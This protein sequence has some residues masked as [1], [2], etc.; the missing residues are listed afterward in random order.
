VSEEAVPPWR[1]YLEAAGL[2]GLATAVCFVFR[3][4][5]QATD[6]AMLYLLVVV[7]VASRRRLGAAVL[8]SVLGI[9]AFD[10]VFVPP[11]YTFAVHNAAYVLTFGVMLAVALV[12][13][14]L[15]ARIRTQAEDAREREERTVALY[16]LSREL[17]DTEGRGNQIALI[18]RHLARAAQRARIPYTAGAVSGIT[19]EEAAKLAPDVIWFQ[20]YRL[21]RDDHRAGFDLLRRAQDA[22]VHVLVMTVDTPGRA[23]RPGELRNGLTL[24]FRPTLRTI[25]QAAVSPG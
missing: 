6:V 24:P 23:K 25:M 7:A 2:V 12:M 20:L 9:A 4:R 21:A 11:Y 16:Q 14:R 19:L 22:G 17:A 5:L 3:S 13:S 8:A 1:G 18:E 15:T 10:F